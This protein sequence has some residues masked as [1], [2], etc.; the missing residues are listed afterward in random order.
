MTTSLDPAPLSVSVRRPSRR[1]VLT[2]LV[3]AFAV[4]AAVFVSEARRV[5]VPMPAVTASPEEVVRSFVRAV[6]AGDL[7][8]AQALSTPEHASYVAEFHQDV[9]SIRDL[10]I[11]TTFVDTPAGG[12]PEV[13]FVGVVIDVRERPRFWRVRNDDIWG[14]QLTRAAPGE[15]WLVSSEGPA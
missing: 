10:R 14:Y 4:A 8:T 11:R 1:A 12:R 7:A 15:R 3:V 9:I 2:T 13:V 6:D 5:D